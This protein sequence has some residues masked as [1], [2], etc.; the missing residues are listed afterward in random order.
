AGVTSTLTHT[1]GVASGNV[2][3]Q[4]PHGYPTGASA[5]VDVIAYSGPFTVG[6]GHASATL[7]AGCQAATLEI[8]QGGGVVDLSVPGGDGGGDDLAMPGGVQDLSTT[9][10]H[11]L[12]T[13]P[14][15]VCPGG[16]VELCFNG[17]DDDCDGHTDCDD[18]DCAP[19]AVCVPPATGSFTY[20]TEEA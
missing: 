3:V 2:E 1:P 9:V 16:G 12:A 14:D 7:T 6:T 10:V 11:D 8:G 5:T 15:M 18:P 17:V 20:D 4:F 19:I 13:P